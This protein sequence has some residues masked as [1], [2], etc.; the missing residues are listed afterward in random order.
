MGFF[1]GFMSVYCNVINILVRIIL[2]DSYLF[3]NM[4]FVN[5]YFDSVFGGLG[6]SDDVVSCVV[7][8]EVVRC[9]V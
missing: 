7:M 8:F 5:G 4:V 6:V 9:F 3:W 1:D 2:I